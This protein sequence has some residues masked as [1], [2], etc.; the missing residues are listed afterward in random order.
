MADASHQTAEMRDQQA[1]GVRCEAH[2]GRRGL[3]RGSA[4]V[5]TGPSGRI[6]DSSTSERFSTASCVEKLGTA[7]DFGRWRAR[8]KTYNHHKYKCDATIR[9]VRVVVGAR[10][11]VPSGPLLDRFWTGVVIRP[12]AMGQEARCREQLLDRIATKHTVETA[13][14]PEPDAGTPALPARRTLSPLHSGLQEQAGR[15][16][17]SPKAGAHAREI[18]R[19]HIGCSGPLTPGEAAGTQT[20]VGPSTRILHIP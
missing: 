12:A 10:V 11:H 19:R 17:N 6:T 1:N 15:P 8:P 7:S 5:G 4:V 3:C 20:P 9:Q 14:C 18:F 13:D 16:E 2:V